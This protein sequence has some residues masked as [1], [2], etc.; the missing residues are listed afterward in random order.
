MHS[1]CS[2]DFQFFLE[3]LQTLYSNFGRLFPKAA[4]RAEAEDDGTE[5]RNRKDREDDEGADEFGLLPI[6]L[7]YCETANESITS[8]L[9][10]SVFQVFQVVSWKMMDTEKKIQAQE[11]VYRKYKTN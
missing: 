1:G 2:I 3:K 5:E 8:A 10:E 9:N 6:V 11:K 7:Q 4:E